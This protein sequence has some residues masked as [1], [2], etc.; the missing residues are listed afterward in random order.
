M[1]PR[2]S[3]WSWR[4]CSPSTCSAAESAGL[5]GPGRAVLARHRRPGRR[6]PAG[7]WASA[8]ALWARSQPVGRLY[9]AEVV[10]VIGGLVLCA[11]NAWGAENPAIATHDRDPAARRL[12]RAPARGCCRVA[13]YGLGGLAAALLAGAA[14]ARL[15][16]RAGDG[17]PRRLVG[18]RPR[19][20]APG[21]G[22]DRRRRRA[23]PGR[24][25]PGP[26]RRRRAGAGAAGAAGQRAGD[27]RHRRPATCS[28]ACATLVVLGLV[29]PSPRRPGPRAPRCSTALGVLGPRAVAAGRPLERARLPR[30]RRRRPI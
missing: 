24:P 3:G 14:P 8:S 27:R 28:S 21:R 9:G 11:T 22:A 12:V 30:A 17:R 13:A 7:A 19:L 10:A 5:A 20:A 18:R 25:R 26:A 4:A 6:R 2:P 29:A 23:P 15:G 16:P 1:P